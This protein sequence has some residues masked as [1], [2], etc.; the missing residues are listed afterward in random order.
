MRWYVP[1]IGLGVLGTAALLGV[2]AS[3]S[4]DL[5][6]E[7]AEN[8]GVRVLFHD[9]GTCYRADVLDAPRFRRY[10][11][12]RILDFLREG[13]TDPN[14]ILLRVFSDTW[15]ECQWPPVAGTALAPLWEHAMGFGLFEEIQAEAGNAAAVPGQG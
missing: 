4:H 15:P 9:N 11:K 3:R 10:L 1:V 6:H 13:M 8:H 7:A 5:K 12:L 2:M 14:E